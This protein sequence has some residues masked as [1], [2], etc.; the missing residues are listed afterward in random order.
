[1][2]IASVRVLS[3]K[4]LLLLL[5]LIIIIIIIIILMMEHFYVKFGDPASAFETHRQTTV[6][7]LPPATAVSVGNYHRH[8][9]GWAGHA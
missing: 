7:T 8:H 2:N 1:M 6:K 4:N 5:L 9:L 3:I